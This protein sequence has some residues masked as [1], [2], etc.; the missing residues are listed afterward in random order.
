MNRITDT[1]R[2][3]FLEETL[4]DIRSDYFSI[5]IRKKWFLVESGYEEFEGDTIREAIDNA[6]M[7]VKNKK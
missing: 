1:E 5:D 4:S 3:D 2:L 6:I 7:G